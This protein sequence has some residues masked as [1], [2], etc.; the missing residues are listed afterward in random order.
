MCA[1][2]HSRGVWCARFSPVDRLVANG[3]ADANFRL[4]AIPD[5]HW[6]RV[7]V[8]VSRY[9]SLKTPVCWPYTE[10]LFQRLT[11]MQSKRKLFLTSCIR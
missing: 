9:W 11:Q 10:K 3:S 7:V 2:G 6:E 8:T 5:M 4:W 1:G